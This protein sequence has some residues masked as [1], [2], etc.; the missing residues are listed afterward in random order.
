MGLI[1]APEIGKNMALLGAA[2]N[3][4]NQKSG[5]AFKKD[6]LSDDQQNRNQGIHIAVVNFELVQPL[7]QQMQH[8]K[9]VGNDKK[10]VDHE[11]NRK[12]AQGLDGL[13]S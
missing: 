10:R 4:A 11:L 5:D 8:Q 7:A 12:S 2:S 6:G 1:W 9:K 13:F 3:E